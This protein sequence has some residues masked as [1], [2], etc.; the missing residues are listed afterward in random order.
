[1]LKW[2]NILKTKTIWLIHLQLARMTS[3]KEWSPFWIKALFQKMLIW[4]Q[5]LK[6]EHHLYNLEGQFSMRKE[7]N[8]LK[9][10]CLQKSSTKIVL[11]L[12]CSQ[13]Y[14]EI[15]SKNPINNLKHLFL[16]I[17]DN[18]QVRF[19]TKIYNF[20]CLHLRKLITNWQS[21]AEKISFK[22]MQEQKEVT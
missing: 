19:R 6:K 20:H 9:V 17:I 18:H 2:R 13:L 5:L 14:N 12:I 15:Q 8:M 1:M 7:I 21:W 4:H 10:R 22:G 11:S 3:I 16:S